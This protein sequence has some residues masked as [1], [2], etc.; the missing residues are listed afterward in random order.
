MELNKLFYNQY[1]D[2]SNPRSTGMDVHK[3]S[4]SH[5]YNLELWFNLIFMGSVG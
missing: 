4:V 5:G 3:L 1:K 2:A